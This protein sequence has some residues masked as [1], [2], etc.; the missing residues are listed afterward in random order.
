MQFIF[1]MI[2]LDS[3]PGFKNLYAKVLLAFVVCVVFATHANAQEATPSATPTSIV[4]PTATLTPSPTPTVT[5]TTSPPTSTP[6]PSQESKK[7]VLGE[8]TK[9]G[10]TNSGREIQKWIIGIVVATFAAII[11]VKIS[12]TR[13]EE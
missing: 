1:S 9:L 4:S 2:R 5:P 11:G 10:S 3:M 8:A 7:E 6:Q 12:R 13:V